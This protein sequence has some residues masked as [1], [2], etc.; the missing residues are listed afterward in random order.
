MNRY[1]TGGP[2]T[3]DPAH[4]DVPCEYNSFLGSAAATASSL[5]NEN[6]SIGAPAFRYMT[7]SW[8]LHVFDNCPIDFPTVGFPWDPTGLICPNTS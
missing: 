7:D 3:S 4:H 6:S 5:R 1:L 2:G 8:V